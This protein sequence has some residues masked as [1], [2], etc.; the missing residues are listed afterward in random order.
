[1]C[2]MW[3]IYKLW[4]FIYDEKGALQTKAVTLVSLNKVLFK[5]LNVKIIHQI[6]DQIK[7]LFE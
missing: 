3:L 2:I 1:M 5:R 6:K 7:R 4:F